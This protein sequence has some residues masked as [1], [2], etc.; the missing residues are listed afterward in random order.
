LIRYLAA[1]LLVMAGVLAGVGQAQ[2]GNPHPVGSIPDSAFLQPEDLDGAIPWEPDAESWRYLRPPQ[3]CDSG[4]YRSGVLRRAEGTIQ[5]LY[6]VSETRPTVLVEYVASYRGNGVRR[7]LGELQRAIA[8]CPDGTDQTGQ[9]TI[10]ETGLTGSDSLLV[11][12][13]EEIEDYGGSIIAKD[14]YLVVARVG[15]VV[16]VLA[17]AGWETGS[18]H[19]EVVRALI[20]AALQRAATLQ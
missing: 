6:P 9:W 17:D 11:R 18:G 12:L 1:A 4:R 13:T 16:V 7:Y 5:A 15:R 20:P 8:A 19:E 10:L 14:T 2:A 3:P